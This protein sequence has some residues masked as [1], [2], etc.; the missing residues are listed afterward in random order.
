[1]QFD[2]TYF[3]TLHR[4][5]RDASNWKRP[6]EARANC[7]LLAKG[8]DKLLTLARGDHRDKAKSAQAVLL[9]F[10]IEAFKLQGEPEATHY[11]DTGA[12]YRYTLQMRGAIRFVG[13][14]VTNPHCQRLAYHL[15]AA[16]MFACANK[17]KECG[18]P[19]PTLLPP[20]KPR[21]KPKPSLTIH[22]GSKE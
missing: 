19:K 14:G 6:I 13:Q 7:L 2:D 1:M 5:A 9:A 22:K 3:D 18:T 10:I 15:C 11:C 17:L 8:L 12:L 21:P 16:I 4:K 20:P